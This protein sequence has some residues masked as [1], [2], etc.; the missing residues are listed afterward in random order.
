MS[1]SSMWSRVRIALIKL[2]PVRIEN[3]LEKGTPDVN[4]AGGEW[5][6]LKWKRKRPKN[7][8]AILKLDHEYTTEQ[9]T[10]A[11]RRIYAGGKVFVL[12]KIGPEY[13]LFWGSVAAE[14]L[15]KVSLNELRAR[16]IK[17]WYKNRLNDVELKTIVTSNYT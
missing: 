3:R 10:W 6:E 14:Y 2:D 12:V 1:E 15:E 5:I 13:L 9:R 7:P 4:L 17:V 11:L 16:A 8:A